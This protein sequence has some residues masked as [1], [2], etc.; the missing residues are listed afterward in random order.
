MDMPANST[1][2]GLGFSERGVLFIVGAVQFI[3]IL[4]FMMIAPLGPRLAVAVGM[5]ESHLADAVAAYT[6]AAAASG[7]IGSTFL[8]RFDR[9]SALLVALAGLVLGTAAGGLATSFG[10]LMLARMLAGAFGGPATSLA[11]AI[12]SDVIPPERRGRAMGAVMGAFAAASVLG[13]PAGLALAELGDW[14]TPF[15]AV[16]GAGIVVVVAV[17][18]LP[19]LRLHLGASR[20]K[21]LP[22]REMLGRRTVLISYAMTFTVNAGAFVLLPNIAT[23]VQNNLGLPEGQLKWM[24]LA[25]GVISFFTTRT[26]GRLLDRVGAF[27]IAAVGSFGF[28]AVSWIGFAEPDLLPVQTH[29]VACMFAMFMSFMFFNGVRNVAYQTLTTRV[30]RPAERARFMSL[31]SAVQHIAA[32]SGAVLSARVLSTA[33]DH[34]LVGMP[35]VAWIS[36]A[37]SLVL[38]VFVRTVEQRLRAPGESS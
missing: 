23:F 32:A 31:Q 28:A 11:V 9:R 6:F 4:D 36:I 15:F 3:N 2:T 34:S 25:G 22:L 12:V 30:P 38:P 17:T 8:D 16:A 21:P 10:G 18:R 14:R 33:P 20:P 7:I 24:Y 37:I 35:T 13:V 27:R 5:P 19:S 26:V 1:T 29:L